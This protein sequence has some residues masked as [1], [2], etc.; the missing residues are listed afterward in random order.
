VAGLLVDILGMNTSAKELR[1]MGS[2][3]LSVHVNK[4]EADLLELKEGVMTG[5][6]KNHAKLRVVRRDIARA[7]TILRDLH[8]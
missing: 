6:E 1:E 3:S 2:K 8:K 4:L 7:R 5:K